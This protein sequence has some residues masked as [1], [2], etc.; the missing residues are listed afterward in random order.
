MMTEAEK[1]G[2]PERGW[3]VPNLGL[4]KLDSPL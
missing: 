2:P 3:T 1:E 4:D